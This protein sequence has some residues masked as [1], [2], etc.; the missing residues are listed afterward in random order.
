MRREAKFNKTEQSVIQV[1]E[2]LISVNLFSCWVFWDV[3]V[4]KK[5]K[6]LKK[7]FTPITAYT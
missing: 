6:Q 4:P 2:K 5:K 1:R 7:Y 3:G